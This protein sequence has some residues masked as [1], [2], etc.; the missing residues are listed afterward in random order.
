M[1]APMRPDRPLG[2]Y[3]ASALIVGLIPVFILAVIGRW[4]DWS[5]L[6][7][8]LAGFLDGLLIGAMISS[9]LERRP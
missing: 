1:G 8:L 6:A 9:R 3:V 5:P 4:W 7:F 2:P